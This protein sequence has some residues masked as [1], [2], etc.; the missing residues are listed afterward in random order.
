M[1]KSLSY[2]IFAKNISFGD[3]EQ[4]GVG[5]LSGSTGH[6]NSDRLSLQDPQQQ[7]SFIPFMNTKNDSSVIRHVGS[8][9]TPVN[10]IYCSRISL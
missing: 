2:L 5:D 1:N 7:R 10:R 4:Q 9:T 8:V 3:A 6:Q